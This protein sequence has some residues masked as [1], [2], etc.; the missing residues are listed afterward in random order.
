MECGEKKKDAIALEMVYTNF[1][2]TEVIGH[3]WLRLVSDLMRKK[4]AL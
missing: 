1:V 2:N 3:P 4:E